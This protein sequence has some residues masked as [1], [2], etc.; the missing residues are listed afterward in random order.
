MSELRHPESADKLRSPHLD[1]YVYT[2]HAK[3]SS[4][5][6]LRLAERLTDELEWTLLSSRITV[7]VADRYA[8]SPP[9]HHAIRFVS[10]AQAAGRLRAHL[11]EI[12]TAP[13]DVLVCF[14]PFLPGLDAIGR[15]RTTLEQDEMAAAAVARI[16]LDPEG[17]LVAFGDHLDA[18]D[19]PLVDRQRAA[20][21][22][23]CYYLPEDLMPCICIARR[24]IGNIEVPGGFVHFPDTVLALLRAARRRGLLMLMDNRAVVSVPKRNWAFD[25]R[26]ILKEAGRAH[27]MFDDQAAVVKR[28][29]DHPAHARERRLT[30]A[31][32]GPKHGGPSLLLDCSNMPPIFN[33]TTEFALGTLSGLDEASKG[34]WSISALVPE[35]AIQ[36]FSLKNRF[37]RIRFLTPSSTE[38]FDVAI[39]LSQAW[40]IDTIAD[41]NRRARSIGLVIL[42]TI[43]PD[44]IY[45]APPGADEAFQFAGE[46][47]DG[48]IYISEFSR[49]QFR[50]RYFTR[51]GMTETVIYLSLDPLDYVSPT[52]EPLSATADGGAILVFGNGYDHKDIPRTTEILA[53]AFPFERFNV[54]GLKETIVGNVS[55]FASGGADPS[56]IDD[57]Y[58]QAKLV[59]FPSFYEGFGIPLVRGLAYGK[60]VIGRRSRLLYEIADKMPPIGRLVTFENSLDLPYIVARL[61]R[62]EEQPSVCLGAALGPD[63]TPHDWHRSGEQL[64]AVAER[65]KAAACHDRWSARDR[66]LS[67]IRAAAGG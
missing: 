56:V 52:K 19:P 51:P 49:H 61:L 66:A 7:V 50:R 45:A 17:H 67:Y 29:A 41:L 15:L 37:P 32:P 13:R 33:G 62:G 20:E 22:E 11:M 59:V 4:G 43:G 58:Q 12:E 64:V 36:H 5:D 44:T 14:D 65:I 9:P 53:T 3:D 24:V 46:H 38:R 6:P 26:T 57:L 47:A 55:G 63:R 25:K 8:T 34:A 1:I 48:L 30:L 18:A 10:A 35:Q 27:R 54:V 16:A 42:D 40:S 28:L 39:R 60:T 2:A 23:P 21:L 31:A